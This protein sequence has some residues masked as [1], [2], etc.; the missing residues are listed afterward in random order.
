MRAATTLCGRPRRRATSH[1]WAGFAD[2]PIARDPTPT[3][4]RRPR[5][6]AAAASPSTRLRPRGAAPARADAAPPPRRRRPRALAALAFAV[7]LV[8]AAVT[9]YLVVRPGDDLAQRQAAAD[10]V[11]VARLVSHYATALKDADAELLARTVS[12]DV[13]REG[14]DGNE[15][16]Q[17]VTSNGSREAIARWSDLWQSVEDYR[18]TGV[19]VRVNGR[20]ATIDAQSRARAW[21]RARS[22]STPGSRMACGG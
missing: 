12:P 19:K 9:G 8:A 10:R 16:P 20:A 15:Q 3:P 2:A 13:V 1:E 21:T 5:T 11:V 6:P 4:A 14:T 7:L 22:G 17:C 18:L